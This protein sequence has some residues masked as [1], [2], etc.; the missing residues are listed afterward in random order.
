MRTRRLIRNLQQLANRPHLGQ[1]PARRALLVQHL[2][3]V[4]RLPLVPKLHP[5]PKNLLVRRIRALEA[6][7]N[8]VD[9][10]LFPT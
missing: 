6:K 9:S 7:R 3:F 2:Q 5:E 1:R 4:R 10:V 8:L